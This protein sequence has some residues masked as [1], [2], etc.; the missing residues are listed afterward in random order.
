[1]IELY[2]ELVPFTN[3]KTSAR[4]SQN[5]AYT[6]PVLMPLSFDVT[7]SY[8]TV[9]TVLYLRNNDKDKFY[10]NIHIC[11][12]APESLFS[13]SDNLVTPGTLSSAFL[14]VNNSIVTTVFKNS[15][16][17]TL[18]IL[19]TE[20]DSYTVPANNTQLNVA[21]F[22]LA[23]EPAVICNTMF[24][25]SGVQ[26]YNIAQDAQA[27]A[28]V[29]DVRFSAGYD[30]ISEN[31]WLTKKRSIV[32]PAI[33]NST[34]PDNSYIPVRMRLTLNRSYGDMLTL[35]R[36]SINVAWGYEGTRV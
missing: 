6:N 15:S 35:R 24:P 25:I 20:Y 27:G 4:A 13:D 8:N 3:E 19:D 16:N 28:E 22:N 18:A 9:E 29:L 11:L 10:N 1:M 23:G 14:S 12:L 17:V 7:S 26:Y 21:S 36:Y 34:T 33:G 32:I 30:E 31:N 2:Q 5:E